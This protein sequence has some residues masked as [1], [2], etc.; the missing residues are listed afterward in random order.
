MTKAPPQ[1][2]AF[3]DLGFQPRFE[4][5]DTC[6]VAGIAGEGMGTELGGGFARF[7]G[8]RIP[9]TTRYDELVLVLEGEFTVHAGGKAHK[10]EPRDTM[11]IPGGTELVY[12]AD[13]ALVFF[14]IHPANWQSR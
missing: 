1:K 2:I 12:E 6:K 13:D 4:H 3:A 8:A 10:L 5:G 14:A 7:G 11:W 9:W